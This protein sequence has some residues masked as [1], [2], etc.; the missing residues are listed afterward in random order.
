MT[1]IINFSLSDI[2]PAIPEL[3]LL[4]LAI[5]LVGIDLVAKDQKNMLPWVT[6]LGVLGVMGLLANNPGGATFGGMFVADSYSLFFKF[7]FLI[8]IAFTVLISARY[9]EV[10]GL[11]HG[12]YYGLLLFSTVGMMFLASAT[13]LISLYLSLELMA[14]SVY[15]L[16]G[17]LKQDIRA[18]EAAIK[19]F[20]M[21]AFSTAILLYG[22]SLI[23]GLTGTTDL[24]LIAREVAQQDLIK[25]PAMLAGLALI[26]AAFCF[27]VAAV[28]FHMWTPDAYD[29]APTSITA[30]MSV[31]PKAAGF[32][33]FGRVF[34]LAFPELHIQ[35]ASIISVIAILT[36]ALGNI[37]ALSQTS[38]KRM[39][40]YSAIA[41]AGYALLGILSGTNEGLSA[42]MNYLLIYA[43][44]NMGA[45]GIMILLCTKGHAG[46]ALEDYKGLGKTHPL[47]AALMLVFM[48]SLTGIPPTAGFV[49]KYY[50]FFS[51]IHAGYTGIVIA[52]C[53][54]SAISAFFYLRVVMYMYMHDP[55][56]E[57]EISM[58]PGL[59]AALLLSV[60]GVLMLGILPGSVIELAGR[61]IMLQ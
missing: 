8:C 40:A 60:I 9:L 46:E 17:L 33:I 18:N 55:E 43:F 23:Y 25:S 56:K 26:L 42:T 39:L 45:F 10:V 53:F 22:I 24:S 13:D 4:I 20:L 35:W 58:A 16:V 19:Y 59:S 54:F 32:A 47:A 14:L 11:K 57:V 2:I 15:C 41:H 6:L 52:A 38:V 5:M 48:F 36:M 37:V 49:G 7:I 21:G 61:S 28:P 44:M 34:L 1:S 12:E 3:A 31:G 30:F 27:K 50:L 29:G 51:A